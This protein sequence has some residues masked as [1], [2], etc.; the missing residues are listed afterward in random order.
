MIPNRAT[1]L[2]PPTPGASGL[3]AAF[4]RLH[5]PAA[6]FLV[7][8]HRRGQRGGWISREV[9]CPRLRHGAVGQWY[10][11]STSALSHKRLDAHKDNREQPA[12]LQGLPDRLRP[13]EVRY[14][15]L[16]KI[17]HQH[18]PHEILLVC[19]EQLLRLES[20]LFGPVP[21]VVL[22][23]HQRPLGGRRGGFGRRRRHQ[24]HVRGHQPG[25]QHLQADQPAV[26]WGPDERADRHVRL[27]G[28]LPDLAQ[29]QRR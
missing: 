13:A 28:L 6:G 8:P 24:V 25:P 1:L 26:Q 9:A 3:G 10:R 22:G 19:P 7:L 27:L 23:R 16:S 20:Q 11:M 4:P 14:R 12:H 5:D 21:T 2:V 29:L 17:E 18:D 15:P